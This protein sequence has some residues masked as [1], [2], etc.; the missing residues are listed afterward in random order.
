V[1]YALL[2]RQRLRL[3]SSLSLSLLEEKKESKEPAASGVQKETPGTP[4][5]QRLL[6]PE[7][8]GSEL[9]LRICWTST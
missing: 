1:K 2:E 5:R 3:S 4:G 9:G 7:K 6:T 8:G